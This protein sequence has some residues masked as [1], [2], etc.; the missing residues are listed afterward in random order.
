MSLFWGTEDFSAELNTCK[1]NIGRLEIYIEEIERENS[2]YVTDLQTFER[3]TQGSFS[4]RFR[5]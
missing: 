3:K 5:I 1:E 2:K 4:L